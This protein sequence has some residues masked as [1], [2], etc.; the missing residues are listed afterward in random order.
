MQFETVTKVY[1]VLW[2]E[3]SRTRVPIK[4]TKMKPQQL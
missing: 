2:N 3:Y 4:Y 1:I